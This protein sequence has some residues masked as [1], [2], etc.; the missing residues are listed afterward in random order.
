V[1]SSKAFERPHFDS[2]FRSESN[3]AAATEP[4]MTVEHWID[5]R[6]HPSRRPEAARAVQ[7]LVRRWA[8]A[9][10]QMT[11]RLDGDIPRIWVPLSGK[12]IAAIK[13]LPASTRSICS[14]SRT[15]I[16][17]ATRRSPGQRLLETSTCWRS[18]MNSN[19]R[20][21]FV[22]SQTTA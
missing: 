22:N 3:P 11:F 6:C 16:T 2:I 9:E 21:R 7:V 8:S 19:W 14:W 4:V 20:Y 15:A 5:L 12:L 13:M 17:C 18:E 1:E 10:L